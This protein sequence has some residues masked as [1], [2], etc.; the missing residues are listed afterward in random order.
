[1]TTYKEF[2]F[3]KLQIY[4][5]TNSN[6][7]THIH[8]FRPPHPRGLRQQQGLAGDD[9]TQK[10]SSRPS[11]SPLPFPLHSLNLCIVNTANCQKGWGTNAY[12]CYAPPPLSLYL[13]LS[14]SCYLFSCPL[15]AYLAQCRIA[16]HCCNKCLLPAVAVAVAVAI[17]HQFI[18][19]SSAA[20]QL[21]FNSTW[22]TPTH[23]H[24]QL[25]ASLAVSTKLA[26]T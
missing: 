12:A 23:L 25:Q 2:E 4:V 19:W 3:R 13:S 20:S 5:E 22:A 11:L 15:Y 26:A 24:K 16:S 7:H 6:T 10:R 14:L 8:P 17:D 21:N 1:M 9:L 18:V